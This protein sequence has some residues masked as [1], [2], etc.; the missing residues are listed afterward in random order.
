MYV[1]EH[2]DLLADT[3]ASLS[4]EGTVCYFATPRRD[5]DRDTV[6]FDRLRSNGFGVEDISAE[7]RETLPPAVA[8]LLRVAAT[9]EPCAPK[10]VGPPGTTRGMRVERGSV[11]GAVR[12]PRGLCRARSGRASRPTSACSDS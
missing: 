9:E 5:V 12:T 4:R 10:R 8:S 2:W 6:F 1:S 3:L 7:V 11:V